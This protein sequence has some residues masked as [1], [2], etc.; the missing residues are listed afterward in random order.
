[1]DGDAWWGWS[2]S[3]TRNDWMYEDGNGWGW[4]SDGGWEELTPSGPSAVEE[5]EEEEEEAADRSRGEKGRGR[6]RDGRGRGSKQHDFS[7]YKR[8]IKRD[9]KRQLKEEFDKEKKRMKK[10]WED[11]VDHWHQ[12]YHAEK[13]TMQAD[14]NAE[15]RRMQKD[16]DAEREWL[17]KQLDTS[18][19]QQASLEQELGAARKSSLMKEA[20]FSLVKTD[21]EKSNAE[22]MEKQSRQAVMLRR[23]RHALEQ[24]VSHDF[25]MKERLKAGLHK[26]HNDLS[27]GLWLGLTVILYTC[28]VLWES[29][30]APQAAAKCLSPNAGCYM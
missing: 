15:K 8:L 9:V 13:E 29:Y 30:R 22:L 25:G 4:T 18:K 7:N 16:F 26:H 17:L 11:E 1:M 20:S 23:Q 2:W 10:E 5:A 24:W 12:V 28:Q 21:L 19:S 3:D 14:F 6:G 27:C